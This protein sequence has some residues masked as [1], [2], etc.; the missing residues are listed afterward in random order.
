MTRCIR[1]SFFA[2]TVAISAMLSPAA[3]AS[4]T[5]KY[6][7][8]ERGLTGFKMYL[9]GGKLYDSVSAGLMAFEVVDSTGASPALQSA[10]VDSVRDSDTDDKDNILTYC[11]EVKQ[12]VVT[13]PKLYDE[14]VLTSAP[15]PYIS[16]DSPNKI[17]SAQAALLVELAS[18]TAYDFW[19]AAATN[20]QA[21]ALQLAMWE[22]VHEKSGTLNVDR[23]LNVDYDASDR[24]TFYV[25]NKGDGSRQLAINLA[26]TMLAALG[27]LAV[28]TDVKLEALTHSEKQDQIYRYRMPGGQGGEV[29][30]P[31]AILTWLGLFGTLGVVGARRQKALAAAAAA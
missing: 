14:N 4:V 10:F 18:A 7:G 29:P 22:I 1:I 20:V 30:E 13:Q 25:D 11:I 31:L 2:A 19:T 9:N 21:A 27:T 16:G 5:I 23:P 3:S 28:D 6:I 8:L 26:N 12:Q 17:S 15:D 24:G